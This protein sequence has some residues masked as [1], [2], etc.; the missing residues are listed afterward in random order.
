MKKPIITFYLALLIVN[1]KPKTKRQIFKE[2]KR[3]Y[4]GRSG[5]YLM[6]F[7]PHLEKK[8]GDKVYKKL[9]NWYKFLKENET[10]KVLKI[11]KQRLRELK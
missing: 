11:V 1:A 9:Y 10:E 6:D 7:V 3:Y 2:V 4:T 5:I 8:Y